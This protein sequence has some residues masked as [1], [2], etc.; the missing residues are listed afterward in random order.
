M[1]PAERRLEAMKG[2][3]GTV[4]VG[5][6]ALLITLLFAN[7]THGAQV[8]NYRIGRTVLVKADET[9]QTSLVAGGANVEIAGPVKGRLSIFGA[10]LTISGN[11]DGEVVFFGAHVV[12]SGKYA[13]RVRG[14]GADVTLAGTFDDDVEIGAAKITVAPTAVLKKDLRY[15][16]ALLDRQEGSQII[17]KL[18]PLKL[19]MKKEKLFEELER[20]KRILSTVGS[21]LWILTIPALVIVGILLNYLSSGYTN[22]VVTT[23]SGSP[24]KSL[25]VGFVFLIVVPVAV[26]IALATLVGIPAGIIAGLLYWIFLY[27]SRIYVGVWIGRKLLGSLKK[28]FAT[29]FFWPLVLGTILISLIS[30]IPFI[31]WLFR[32]LVLLLGL[33]AMW[34]ALWKSVQESR[35]T[36]VPYPSVEEFTVPPPEH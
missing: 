28:S 34:L 18:N 4:A 13:G 17:G 21:L 6:L 16:A 15:S 2:K 8:G 3:K 23:V 36:L 35:E 10:D 19:P 33:G 31:G 9:V 14:A 22:A 27:L 12:L 26:L 25:A 11:V 5:F 24:W 32:F 30:L 7:L 29:A 20:G 1:K